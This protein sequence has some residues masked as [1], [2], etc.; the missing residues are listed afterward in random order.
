MKIRDPIL[1]N[2]SHLTGNNFATEQDTV[3]QKSALKTADVAIGG[4]VILCSLLLQNFITA[5]E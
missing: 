3:N 5:R 2:T 1:D 4:S